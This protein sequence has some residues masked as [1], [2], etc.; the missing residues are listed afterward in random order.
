MS[1]KIHQG[2][3]AV[4]TGAGSGN[5]AAIARRLAEE[6]AEVWLLD[7]SA[8]G[9][10]ST[11]GG[12]PG[13]L[14]ERARS[15]HA[16]ITD[17]D[18]VRAAFGELDRLDILVNNAGIVDP[19]T[20]PELE[21][22]AFG[23]VLD[24]NLLGAYR[25]CV[26]AD[27]LLRESAAGRVVNVTSMEAHYLLSTGGQVQPHYNASKAGLD[28]LT[29]ALAYELAPAGVTVNAIA[30]GVIETPFTKASLAREEISGWIVDCV[31]IGR[32]G[33]PEDIAAAASFLASVD[34]GYV[35]GISIP[36]DGGFTMGW[37]RRTG[38][39]S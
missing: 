32:I 21:V 19:G 27:R 3:A 17:E 28:L 39:G 35:T 16:D 14:R 15:L 26:A 25:C 33:R 34:A 2:R 12:W 5:G 8:E 37:F 22:E 29:K 1:E 24:V 30:P 23:R 10:E 20:Y 38:G 6:G 13:D 31:P 11:I 18:Q 9:L 4:V 7:R 36:V